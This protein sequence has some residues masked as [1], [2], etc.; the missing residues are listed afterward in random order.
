[1]E[2]GGYFELEQY[3]GDEYHKDCLKLNTARNCLKYLI[4]A[5]QVKKLW[6][7]RWNCS[8]VLD[9]CRD[10]GIELGY[11]DLD[12][13]FIPIMPAEYK[14]EDYVYVVNYYGQLPEVH[15][16]HMI[17]DNVQAFFQRPSPGIDTIYTC[18]KYF[19]V[20]DG[21]Y[22]Y[23]NARL[24]RELKQDASY[25][26]IE[27]LA[28]RF[29]KSASEFYSCYQDNEERL[30]SLPLMRM[31]AFTE[32][33]LRSIDYEYVKKRREENFAYLDERLNKYNLLKVSCTVGPFAYPLQVNDGPKMRRKLQS[34]KIY[35]A[36]LWPNLSDGRAGKLADNILPIPCDQRYG[37]EQMKWIVHKISELIELED[38]KEIQY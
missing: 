4:E 33:I 29:E 23:T 17:L 8:A 11:F 16:E 37:N 32:N 21:A 24:N 7:S 9:T 12:D 28:G 26:R 20:T 25:Q 1:M 27:Y 18:R 3:Q 22:L 31:S 36:K 6:I 5:R 14:P 19:G 10:S 2:I 13:E 15:F 30:D 35:V 38:D 34:E